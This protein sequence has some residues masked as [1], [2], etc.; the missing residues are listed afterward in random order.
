MTSPITGKP[1]AL[2][3]NGPKKDKPKVM[4]SSPTLHHLE[5][6]YTN[7]HWLCLP[8]CLQEGDRAHTSFSCGRACVC[9]RSCGVCA[10]CPLRYLQNSEPGFKAWH[11]TGCPLQ[12]NDVCLSNQFSKVRVVRSLFR[13]PL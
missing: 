7:A 4:F 8:L 9:R 1:K 11:L 6:F 12:R 2:N 5:S 10:S 13:I 3:Q